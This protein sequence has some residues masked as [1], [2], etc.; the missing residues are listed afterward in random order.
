MIIGDLR[1]RDVVRLKLV[2]GLLANL[3]IEIVE[4]LP[5]V[6]LDRG[7]RLRSHE[8]HTGTEQFRQLKEELSKR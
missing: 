7:E 6:H 4:R 5:A 1:H 8:G 2:G 3:R